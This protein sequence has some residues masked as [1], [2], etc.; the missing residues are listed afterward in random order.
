MQTWNTLLSIV[1]PKC[2][3]DHLQGDKPIVKDKSLGFWL[4]VKLKKTL[5]PWK[6]SYDRPR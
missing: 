2:D 6:K 3:L 1:I 5:A 4:D